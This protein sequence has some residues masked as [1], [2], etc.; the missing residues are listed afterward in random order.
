MDSNEIVCQQYSPSMKRYA[1]G[2][3]WEGVLSFLWLGLVKDFRVVYYG[4]SSSLRG[5]E[6]LLVL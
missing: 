5:V 4:A 6:W 1:N 3:Q 2:L